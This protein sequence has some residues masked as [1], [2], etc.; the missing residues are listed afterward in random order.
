MTVFSKCRRSPTKATAKALDQCFVIYDRL[1]FPQLLLQHY[2]GPLVR[3]HVLIVLIWTRISTS[4]YAPLMWRRCRDQRVWPLLSPYT[5]EVPSQWESNFQ[6]K[7]CILCSQLICLVSLISAFSCS[8]SDTSAYGNTMPL[9]DFIYKSKGFH[10]LDTL[11][12]SP[13]VKGCYFKNQL[14]SS[15]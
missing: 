14:D 5:A 13:K 7:Y 15:L 2:W 3:D 4:Q 11:V 9:I 1:Y 12:N 10:Y 6:S 8:T